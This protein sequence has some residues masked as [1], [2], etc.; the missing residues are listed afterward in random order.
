MRPYRELGVTLAKLGVAFWNS[1]EKQSNGC[2]L[3]KDPVGVS[4]YGQKTGSVDGIVWSAKPHIMTWEEVHGPVPVGH[5]LRRRKTCSRACVNPAHFALKRLRV[6]QKYVP[7]T[8][9][10][11][12]RVQFM[13]QVEKTETCW[14]WKGSIFADTGYGLFRKF[15]WKEPIGA[16]R[17]SAMMFIGKIPKGRTVLHVVCD[18]PPCVNPAHLRIG[19]QRANI[20]DAS[21]KNRM[22]HGA[23][24]HRAKVT[25]SIVRQMREMREAG[26]MVTAIAEKFGLRKAQASAIINRKAWKHVA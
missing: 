4:G 7:A 22:S 11:E 18:N 19:T 14:L 21:A 25:D 1:V 26:E 5:Q 8:F 13:A 15:G 12:T 10:E 6:T 17:A 16:H 24:H 2:W 9:D 20:R 3:W 23:D